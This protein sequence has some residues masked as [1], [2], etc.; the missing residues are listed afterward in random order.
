[1]FLY[2]LFVVSISSQVLAFPRRD[3]SVDAELQY[4]DDV[5][6]GKD[7]AAYLK[8]VKK[9]SISD[10][11]SEVRLLIP[12]ENSARLGGLQ[13][14]ACR[15]SLKFALWKYRKPNGSYDGLP[16]FIDA[17]CKRLEIE[18]NAV[19]DGIVTTFKPV[20]LT[21]LRELKLTAD[22]VCG[23]ILPSTCYS[24]D[25]SWNKIKW[26]ITIPGKILKPDSKHN[27]V[28]Q[29]APSTLKVLQISDIHVDK[30]Y[31][32]N[33]SVDCSDPLCCRTNETI[34][35]HSRL[36]GY[37]GSLGYCDTPYWTL[38]ALLQHLSKNTYDYIIWTG[39]LPAHDDWSQS[40]EDQ[41]SALYAL[42]EMLQKYFPKTRI[43][44]SLGNHESF[45]VNNFPPQYVNGTSSINWLYSALRK[46]WSPWLPDDA[47]DTVSQ[48]GYYTVLVK[49]KFRIISL[50]MNYCNQQNWWMLINPVDP[51]HELQW[52]VYVLT[53]AE[54][55]GERVHILGHIPPG[56]DDCLPIWSL[57]YY[58]IIN[59]F[60]E[61]ISA[62]FFGH[63]HYDEMEI[64]YDEATKSNA[65]S[66]AYIA[67]SVTTYYN[68][69]P[70]YREYT[71]EGFYSGSQWDVLDHSNYILNLT[72][73]NE[74]PQGQIPAWDFLYS[75]KETY[76]MPDLKPR[77]WSTLVNSWVSG[78]SPEAE[79]SFQKYYYYYY[80]G[81]PP[82]EKCDETC[83]KTMLCA[84]KTAR[85]GG[86]KEFCQ[87]L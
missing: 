57:N 21:L 85:S 4:I 47:L 87:G 5:Y 37:W 68:M 61:T 6:H 50:N 56:S 71:M 55:N 45:P 28:K 76:K 15:L 60:K 12:E 27:H 24:P 31:A 70:G 49:P 13:C 35:N 2:C 48:S 39:D 62:Q 19:C 66:M 16:E 63:T 44:P 82:N 59:R 33:S 73:A 42:T 23:L 86:S 34:K 65:T 14:T 20:V 58:R 36:A 52:L 72:K 79:A 46:A 10:P 8:A 7:Q 80:K 54:E 26:N 32:P 51:N 11:N 84:I 9:L 74:L 17:T 69:H 18:S 77:S 75:A 40:R 1:M 38:E 67:P 30:A 53:H 64:F 43:F 25:L 41:V 22:E 29:S 81:N 78:K 83:K 3:A